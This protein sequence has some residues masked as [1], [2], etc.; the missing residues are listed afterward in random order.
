M[1]GDSLLDAPAGNATGHRIHSGP[2]LLR[3]TVV[4]E[5]VRTE[6]DRAAE[7]APLHVPRRS[8]PWT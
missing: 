1:V 5:D 6:L 8:P 4:G 7:L 2:H 3:A